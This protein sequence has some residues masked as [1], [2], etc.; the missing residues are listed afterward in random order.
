M[1]W[2][3]YEKGP[4]RI[5]FQDGK[6][7]SFYANRQYWD[8]MDN[9]TDGPTI[10]IKEGRVTKKV[11]LVDVGDGKIEESTREART[12]SKDKKTVT[13]EVFAESQDGYI[14]GTK[15]IEN[16]VKGKT[17]KSTRYNP[18]GKIVEIKEF[19]KDGKATASYNFFPDGKMSAVN[20]WG[21]PFGDMSTNDVVMKKGD[22]LNHQHTEGDIAYMYGRVK[23]NDQV[24]EIGWAPKEKNSDL[25][26]VIKTVDGKVRVDLKKV[27]KLDPD[28]KGIPKK[29][30]GKS[31]IMFSKDGNLE[32]NEMLERTKGLPSDYK[33]SQAKAKQRG[34]KKGRYKFWIPPSAD[35][36]AGLL[37]A[38]QGKGK[39]GIADAAWL[40]EKL[41][42]PY[43]KGDRDLNSARQMTAMEFKALRKQFPKV[44]KKLRKIIPTGDYNYG[45][46]MR[47]YL[48][49]KAGMEIPGLSN[50]D[51]QN[52]LDLV[53][54]DPELQAFA[55]VLGEI[56]RK[57]EGYIAPDE[58]WMTKDIVADITEDGIIG[59]GRKEHFV[60]WKE[61]KDIIFSPENM[62]KI[63]FIYGSNFR[64]ALEDML[65]RMENGSNR[66]TGQNRIVNNFI[67]WLNGGISVVMNWNSRSAV[68]QTLSTVNFINWGDNNVASAAK[69]FANQKQFWKDF[70]FIFNS[71][72]LRQRRA[73][74]KTTI[75]SNELMS[76]VE[77]SVNPARAAIRYL[78]RVGFTPT[79]IAD[80][81]A[82]AMGGS[83]FYRNRIKTYLK[84]GMTQTEAEA[85]AWLDFQEAA[86]ETQQS[87]R[88]DRI[89]MQQAS[90]LGRL[91]LAF[92]NTPMQYMR[93]S[94][95]EILNIVNGRYEG[96]TGPNSL[97]S[98]VGKIA[99]YTAIQ[100]LIFYSMQSALFA[101][102]FSDD[103]DDEEFFKQKKH[104]VAD[105]MA[106]GVLR[107]LGVHGAVIAT[108]KNII[109]KRAAGDR[110]S[111]L[112]EALK[113]SP[114][115]SIKAR[116][117]LSA[118]RTLRWDKDIMKEM[119]TF[120]IDN[121]MWNAMFNVIEFATNL[122]LA[123]METK[124]KNVRE[125]LNKQHEAWQR[126]A[127]LLGWAPWNFGI[128]N[129]QIE[130][131]KEEIKTQKTYERKKKQKIKKVEKQAEEQAKIDKQIAK[132]KELQEKGVLVDPKCRHVSTKGKRCRNS[133]AN[134][135]DACTIH[136]EVKQRTDGKKIQC[137]KIKSDGKKCK[138]KTSAKSGLC[139]YHD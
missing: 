102:M 136:E 40:K 45:D 56:S 99:Y 120:D 71:D 137:K 17:I 97:A 101:M 125:S 118:D 32:F 64:E 77:G 132:E 3:A 114:P 28:A 84:Q 82:I 41:L 129:K 111:I 16:R 14:E 117:L 138:M 4:K 44:S 108:I 2:T 68:L 46:A 42:D 50:T 51:K 139:Y 94:K 20:N 90:V 110:D 112:V 48:W 59:D 123:R 130:E 81:F 63:E 22:V 87:S 8:R 18:D 121:P 29:I 74:L 1:D 78:L 49:D 27:L 65:Y 33:I 135:G 9:A 98:K 133:V 19:N 75:E 26:N 35:D 83:T 60:E 72:M 21:Q 128:K 104:R 31:V 107:G 93:L 39:Q 106:D 92:Q 95:K 126:I 57:E 24:T 86:E 113:V 96:V 122:P 47:V 109:L 58:Y 52:M 66:P 115:L 30:S 116:Q 89:S 15:I 127:F 105:N 103:E 37:M 100:N 6:L 62:N 131:V 25:K 5:I 73:G 53:A 12:V 55:D 119:E 134:A 70:A 76:E 43:A 69:A 124:Y 10:S 7:S 79:K 88:P 85:K 36:F 11:E 91:I 54:G 34:K 23:L 61:N 13:T 67:N 80:S 38:F